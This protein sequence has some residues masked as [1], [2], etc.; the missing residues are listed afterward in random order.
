MLS[1]GVVR[2][3]SVNA[4]DALQPSGPARPPFVPCMEAAGVVVQIGAGTETT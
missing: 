1:G 4:V 3:A 2:A